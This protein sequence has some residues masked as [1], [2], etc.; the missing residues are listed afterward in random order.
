ME[1]SAA[2]DQP[3]PDVIIVVWYEALLA[4]SP[5]SRAPFKFTW[6]CATR[7]PEAGCK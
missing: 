2:S 3:R 4:D 1:L 5:W 6:V 7:F